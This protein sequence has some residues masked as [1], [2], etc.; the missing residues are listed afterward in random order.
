[1][2]PA[3][4][5]PPSSWPA[6][7]GTLRWESLPPPW[8]TA[9]LIVPAAALLVW[10]A[11]RREDLTPGKRATLAALRLATVLA[12]FLLLCGPYLERRETRKVSSHLVVMIDSSAS[13]AVA[14]EVDPKT[15]RALSEAT[16]VPERDLGRTSRLEL[17]RRALLRGDADSVLESL[18]RKFVLHLYSFAG[19]SRTLWSG[20]ELREGA[21]AAGPR[22]PLEALRP[23]GT[24]TRLGDCTISAIEDFRLRDEPLAGVV[25]VSDGR[26]TSGGARTPR[27]AAEHARGF[28]Q[29]G[30]MAERGVPIIAVIAGDPSSSRNVQVR[31]LVAPEVVLARDDASFEFDVVEKGFDGES[32]VLRLMFVEP[33]GENVTLVPGEVTLS[34]EGAGVRV[35][36]RHRFDR[37]GTYRIR[38]GVPP[39]HGERVTEDNWVEHQVRVVDRKVKVLYVDGRPRREWESLQRALTRDSETM[40]VHTLQLDARG[41][42]QPK[43]DAPG[44]PSLPESGFPATRAELFRY[45]VV[46]LGDADWRKF[47]DTPEDR[48]QRL[49]DLR[50]FVEAGGGLLLIAGEYFMPLEYRRTPLAEVFPVIVD[51]DEVLRTQH[52]ADEKAFNLALTPEGRDSPLFRIDDD[53][54]KSRELWETMTRWQQWWYFPAKRP[55]AG[56]RVLAVHPAGV[57]EV[58]RNEPGD[59]SN[60]YGPHVLAATKSF[61]LGRSLWLGMDELWRMRYGVGDQYYYAFY[62]KAIRYLASY[63]LLGGNR[64]VKIHPERQVY[65]LDEPVG[66]VAHAVGEDFR[67]PSPSEKPRV[68]AVITGPDRTE[69]PIDLLPSALAE[70]EAP[71]GA[72]RGTFT[73]ALPGTYSVAPDPAEVPGEEPEQRSFVVESSAEEQKDPSVDEEALASMAAASAPGGAGRPLGLAEVSKLPELLKSRDFRIPVEAS[74]D[75]L[76]NQ[77]WIPLALTVLLALE[78]LLRKRWRLL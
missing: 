76:T 57:Q 27:E 74:T 43:T 66:I 6:G 51:P 19:E 40:L 67:P 4:L 21:S 20:D 2:T 37:P 22:E 78:W 69:H 3:D 26:Q 63:R 28:L 59:H 42:P 48:M 36:A 39:L 47:A 29:K 77:W 70:G 12:A 54:V 13:M 71:L 58:A 5:P 55:A 7:G 75:P 8:A 1:M 34:P 72:Y 60:R 38:V 18:R 14:D 45:D 35:K 32:G 50:D 31:N 68:A 41:V 62:A 65:Y 11:Y 23:D 10:L 56:A 61:G 44:W 16:G 30:S 52:R 49:Q 46:V 17:A 73:P 25:V 9:L 24:S 53:A 33:K 64:R 15:A